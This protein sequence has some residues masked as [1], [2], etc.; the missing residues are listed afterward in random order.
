MQ[1]TIKKTIINNSI[2]LELITEIASQIVESELGSYCIENEN[3]DLVY[4]EE[5]QECFN[6]T[7]D[8]IECLFNKTGNIFSD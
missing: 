5:Q 8:F 6:S 2:Y 4:S 3:G 7:F 1:K